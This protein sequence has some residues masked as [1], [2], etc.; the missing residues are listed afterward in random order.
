MIA[1]GKAALFD[2]AGLTRSLEAAYEIMVDRHAK[3]QNPANFS[4]M[5]P[6]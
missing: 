3:G 1:A 4:V 6:V 5:L 2:T